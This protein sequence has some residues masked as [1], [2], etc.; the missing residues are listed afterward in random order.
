M[1]P[2]QHYFRCGGISN[3]RSRY[4]TGPWLLSL[5]P[6]D[7]WAS[8]SPETMDLYLLDCQ[9]RAMREKQF[10][11]CWDWGEGLDHWYWAIQRS[12]FARV[13]ALC[14]LPRKKS[15]EVAAHFRADFWVGVASRCRIAKQYKCQYCCSCKNYHGKGMEGGKCLRRFLADQKI[16]SS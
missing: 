7:R 16:A 1:V 15:R 13:N 2:G 5:G 3:V 14:N 9:P 12:W 6:K 8:Q 4:H 10:R 11:P